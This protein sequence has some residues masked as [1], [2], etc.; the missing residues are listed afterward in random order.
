MRWLEIA[1]QILLIL[2]IF[3][4][5]LAAPVAVREINEGR[6]NAVDV[7]TVRM[8]ALE[9]RLDVEDRWSTNAVYLVDESTGSDSTASS[10]S[11]PAELDT[12]TS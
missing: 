1:S 6:V 12:A 10:S 3:N 2:S 11:T 8:A 7:A 9:K 4:I 5:V